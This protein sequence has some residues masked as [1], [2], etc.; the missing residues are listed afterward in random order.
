[1]WLVTTS[2]L[3]YVLQSANASEIQFTPTT[4]M[5]FANFPWSVRQPVPRKRPR[6]MHRTSRLIS[7]QE[8]YDYV[9]WGYRER[10]LRHYGHVT[11]LPAENPAHRILSCRDLRGWSMPRGRPQASCLRLVEAYLGLW[12]WR[13]WG[14]LGDGQTEA[15]GVPLQG[16]RSD[17]LLRRMPPYLTWH[18]S[19]TA[20]ESLI[21]YSLQYCL[22]SRTTLRIQWCF[23]HS[24]MSNSFT[25]GETTLKKSKRVVQ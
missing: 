16:G 14:L 7:I 17:A 13:A 5:Y 22:R 4:N 3:F 2:T 18:P 21:T 23:P 6:K 10:Q 11:R 24:M 1:M 12:A 15:E 25:T 9:I 8:I 19:L 20:M